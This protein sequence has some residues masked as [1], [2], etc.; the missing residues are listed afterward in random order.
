MPD[1]GHKALIELCEASPAVTAISLTSEEEGIGLCAGAWL[2]GT[3]RNLAVAVIDNERYGKT[4]QQ[5][6]H[7]AALTDLEAVARA[8]GIAAA[9]TIRDLA[10]VTAFRDQLRGFNGPRFAAIT[11]AHDNPGMVLPS[12]D[13]ATIKARFRQS[14]NAEIAAR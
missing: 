10:G 9:S 11:V 8:V 5:K 2:G 13:G 14:L 6:T 4:G 1:A 3:R 7:T 12:N